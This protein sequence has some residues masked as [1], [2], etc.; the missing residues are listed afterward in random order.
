V[1]IL[2]DTNADRGL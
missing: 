2:T 1:G